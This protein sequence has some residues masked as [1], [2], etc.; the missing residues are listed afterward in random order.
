MPEDV[1]MRRFAPDTSDRVIGMVRRIPYENIFLCVRRIVD[2]FLE[3]SR[4]SNAVLWDWLQGHIDTERVLAPWF[5]R[6]EG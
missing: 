4:L 2:G 1:N 6:K 5:G 3:P